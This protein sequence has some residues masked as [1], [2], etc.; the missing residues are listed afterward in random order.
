MH[1]SQRNWHAHIVEAS[2]F[3]MVENFMTA[4]FLIP[5]FFVLH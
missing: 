2:G 3:V 5:F 4:L 1:I